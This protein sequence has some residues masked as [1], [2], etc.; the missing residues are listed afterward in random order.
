MIYALVA[1]LGWG[2]AAG[3]LHAPPWIVV[4]GALVA[5]ALCLWLKRDALR[6]SAP[7]DRLQRY[8]LVA[9]AYAFVSCVA[10]GFV[11]V[12]FYLAA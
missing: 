3:Y 12:A 4:V 8:L 9:A 6:R 1:A 10:F 5:A 11:G 7:E 2:A